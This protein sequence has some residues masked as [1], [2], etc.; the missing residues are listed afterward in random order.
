MTKLELFSLRS[1]LE[2][3]KS[4]H[5]EDFA[6]ISF[7]AFW[8]LYDVKNKK[9]CKRRREGFIALTGLGW[10]GHAKR[11][12]PEHSAYA[13]RNLY[14]YMPC[15]GMQGT[16]YIDTVV[17]TLFEGSYA[18]AFYA[19]VQDPT[20]KWCPPWVK[21]NYE[22]HNKDLSGQAAFDAEEVVH[23]KEK[24]DKEITDSSKE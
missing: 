24:K 22:N 15:E 6:N 18:A 19:F 8:R 5:E 12:H 7:Y 13:R 10:S 3:P 14:A 2:R 11:S 20:N 1:E 9:L 4:I 16:E 21:R 17:R 23:G